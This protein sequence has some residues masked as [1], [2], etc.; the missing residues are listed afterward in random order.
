MKTKSLYKTPE[1]KQILMNLYDSKMDSLGLS[2]QD[3]Y[4]DTFAGKT[5]VIKTGDDSKPPIVL[6][7]GINAGAPVA[8]EPLKELA[9]DYLIYAIDT[10]G[11]TTKSAETRLDLNNNDYGK[12]LS[13]TFDQLGIEKAPVI[14]ASYGGFLLQKLIISNPEKV[15]KAVFVVPAGFGNGGFIES[16]KRL[17]LPLIK[18][19]TFKKKSDLRSFMSSFHNRIDDYWLEFQKNTLLGVNMDYR[20]PPI[21]KKEDV[22][23]FKSPVYLMVAEDDVFFPAKYAIEKCRSYFKNFKEVY[24]LKNSKHIP[25]ASQFE[26]IKSA[27]KDW[28]K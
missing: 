9:E 10:I 19:M 4:V 11:Q 23:G 1:T 17:T 7:H 20:R 5:H 28:L 15:S 27:I 6:L 24:T 25:E 16:T 26:E 14:A 8:I 3:L 21:L 18:F 13:E 2:Y 22:E 12:W